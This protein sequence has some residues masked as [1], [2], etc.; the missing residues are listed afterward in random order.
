MWRIARPA[1]AGLLGIA[2]ATLAVEKTGHESGEPTAGPTLKFARTSEQHPNSVSTAGK[3]EAVTAGIFAK[4]PDVRWLDPKDMGAGMKAPVN[5]HA[6]ADAIALAMPG[7]AARAARVQ[8]DSQAAPDAYAPMPEVQVAAPA[9]PPDPDLDAAR[10]ALKALRAG[11]LA[12][13]DETARASRNEVT[14]TM[15]EYAALRLQARS[16]GISRIS[17]FMD[18]H[19]DW[20][21][22]MQLERRAEEALFSDKNRLAPVR[23]F[24]EHRSPVSPV[25]KLAQARALLAS[26]KKQEAAALVASVW[27]REEL[28]ASLETSIKKEFG[29]LLTSADHRCRADRFFYREK[30]AVSLR[31]ATYAGGETLALERARQAVAHNAHNSSQRSTLRTAIKTARKALAG[32][33]KATA[34]EVFRQATSVIDRIADKKIIH[35]NKAARHKSRLAAALKAMSA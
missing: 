17:A 10:E 21:G 24:F 25:G 18:H 5:S 19:S 27:C 13:A 33:D 34:T 2:V 6:A 22:L 1:C 12:K 32:G 26:D 9:P 3:T 11:D 4:S 28:G 35:K 7:E 31:A 30:D 29:A 14:R 23:S 20:P 15:L 16:V 8:T